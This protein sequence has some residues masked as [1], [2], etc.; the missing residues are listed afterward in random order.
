MVL[1]NQQHGGLDQ[2]VSLTVLVHSGCLENAGFHTWTAQNQ[3]DDEDRLG[4]LVAIRTPWFPV[5][6]GITCRFI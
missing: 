5:M 2:C 4:R 3:G 1:G 6:E